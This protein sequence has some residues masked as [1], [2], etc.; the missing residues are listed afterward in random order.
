MI[1][2]TTYNNKEIKYLL[3]EY[4]KKKKEI[5]SKLKE[6]IDVPT[7]EY[8]YELI[9]CLFTP[10][11]SAENCF[12]AVNKIRERKYLQKS[13]PLKNILH[14]KDGTYIR[15]HNNKEKY[16]RSA[17]RNYNTIIDKLATIK[18]TFELREWLVKNIKGLSYKEST[19]FL[20]NIGKNGNLAILDRHIL[21]NL[22]SIGAICEIP[23][24]LNRKKYLEI[25]NKFQI[26]ADYIKIN[27]NELDLLFWSFGTGIILK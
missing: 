2:K 12:K 13:F 27:I 8:F 6:F 3:K 26:F 20:R 5:K 15:F 4:K 17:K 14:D 16:V 10:Q 1:Q 21:K 11:S 23:T 22:L 9:F 24:T 25:E 7:D 18:N 19:H